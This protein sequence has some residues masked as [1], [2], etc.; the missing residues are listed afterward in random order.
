MDSLKYVLGITT[1][2]DDYKELERLAEALK[3]IDK[4]LEEKQNENISVELLKNKRMYSIYETDLKEK[5]QL[6]CLIQKIAF[7]VNLFFF[8]RRESLVVPGEVITEELLEQIKVY[9]EANMNISG[10]KDNSNKTIEV[11]K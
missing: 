6:I 8:I 4:S 9:L 2:C 7:Q 3:E 10:L 1:I 11:V 5:I